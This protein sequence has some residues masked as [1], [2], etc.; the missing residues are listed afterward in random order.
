M[1]KLILALALL[2]AFG[3]TLAGCRAEA[4]IDPDGASTLAMPR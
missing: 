4:E 3:V 1:N 2:S